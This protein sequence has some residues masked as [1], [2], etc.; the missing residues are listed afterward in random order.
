MPETKRK[1]LSEIE[2]FWM[3]K[4]NKTEKPTWRYGRLM[5]IENSLCN[6]VYLDGKKFPRTC[7]SYRVLSAPRDHF[8]GGQFAEFK[9]RSSETAID[10]L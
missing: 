6:K 8:A 2:A 5:D 3:Q 4:V 1:K 9:E 10:S 7:G